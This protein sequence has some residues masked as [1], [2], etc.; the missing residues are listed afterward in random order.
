MMRLRSS[1][2]R[3]ISR[4]PQVEVAILQPQVLAGQRHAVAVA[5]V[6]KQPAAVVAIA[7]DPAAESY[8]LAYVFAAQF[9]AGVSS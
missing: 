1:S 6:D 2:V 7:I 9:A 5:Q 8:F 4:P 3:C